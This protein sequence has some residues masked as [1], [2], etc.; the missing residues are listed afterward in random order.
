M[1]AMNIHPEFEGEPMT[2]SSVQRRPFMQRMSFLQHMPLSAAYLCQDCNCIGNCSEQCPAC[3]SAALIGLAGVLNRKQVEE[4]P[5]MNRMLPR[6]AY[7]DH[8]AA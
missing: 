8:I 5:Q 1:N 7:S 3:A 6:R 4:A 2:F